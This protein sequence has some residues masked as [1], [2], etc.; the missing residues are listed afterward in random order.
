MLLGGGG[1]G[2][3]LEGCVCGGGGGVASSPRR[4]RKRHSGASA[5]ERGSACARTCNNMGGIIDGDWRT[6]AGHMHTRRL[7]RFA[8]R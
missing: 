5:G 3:R 8:R 1:G 6:H 2:E 4:R 7:L